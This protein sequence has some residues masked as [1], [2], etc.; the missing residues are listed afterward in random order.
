MYVFI[1][2]YIHVSIDT[3][4]HVCMYVCMYVYACVC[5][6]VCACVFVCVFVCVCV[7]VCFCVCVCVFVWGRVRL[8]GFVRSYVRVR[9]PVCVCVVISSH[10]SGPRTTHLANIHI[11]STSCVAC[12]LTFVAICK[13]N[14]IIWYTFK[15]EQQYVCILCLSHSSYIL[16]YFWGVLCTLLFM[17]KSFWLL[18]IQILHLTF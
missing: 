16:F 11:Q 3:C 5:L 8:G 14:F 9:V 13:C 7:C 17:Y 10:A 1:Y 15:I 12:H 4:I 6:C 18:I 2:V